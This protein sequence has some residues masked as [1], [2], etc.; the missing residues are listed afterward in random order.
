MGHPFRAAI[1]ARD[2]DAAVA[3]LREDVVFRSPVV[4]TPYEGR[5]ALRQILAAVIDVFEDFRYIREIGAAGAADHALVFE[6]RVGDKQVQGCDF[7]HVDA[8]GLI[9]EFT[10]MVRPLQAMLAL[11]EAMK[12]RLAAG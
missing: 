6:A 11:A 2:L 1:E 9:D 12:A 3:L 7:I 8:N 10:V 4:F 5:E